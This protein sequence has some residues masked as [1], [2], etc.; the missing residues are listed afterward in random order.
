[1]YIS[2]TK[3]RKHLDIKLIAHNHNC[4]H[5]NHQVCSCSSIE[6]VNKQRYLGLII[7]DRLK[8]NEHVNYVCDKLRAML[9]KFSIVKQKIP[10]STLLQ[11][12]K[13]LGET[14]INYCISSYGRTC[15]TNLDPIY[16]LQLRILKTIV[17][18]KIKNKFKDKDNELFYHC[19]IL[20]IYDQIKV[21]LL[22]ENFFNKKF[23]NIKQINKQTRSAANITLNIP[24]FNN[25]YGKQLL[26]YQIP[27]LINSLPNTIKKELKETN[28]KY[29]LK[30]YFMS[31]LI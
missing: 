2:S 1:M 16:K 15:K 28:I 6:I 7:D 17:P 29:K 8:W 26:E 4:F 11:L 21:N 23:Y 10:Y 24:R 30:N 3:N 20:P 25:L 19:R 27:K 22:V 9:A 31:L 18:I 12:Y 5:F 13:A 14:I